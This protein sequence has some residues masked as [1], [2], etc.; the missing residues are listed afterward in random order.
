M[1]DCRRRSEGT[2][3][4]IIITNKKVLSVH[5]CKIRAS[6]SYIQIFGD[7]CIHNIKLDDEKMAKTALQLIKEEVKRQSSSCRCEIVIDIGEIR[8][9]IKTEGDKHERT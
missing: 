8:E 6:F 1:N 7:G 4:M 2:I 9:R 5:D 3:I